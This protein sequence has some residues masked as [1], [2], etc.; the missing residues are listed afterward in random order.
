MAAGK[1][2]YWLLEGERNDAIFRLCCSLRRY[3]RDDPEFVLANAAMANIR[4]VPPMSDQELHQCVESAFKQDHDT[5][6]REAS[7]WV[8]MLNASEG[9][10]H[11]IPLHSATNL[12]PFPVHALP[13]VIKNWCEAVSHE[14]QMPIELAAGLVFAVIATAFVGRVKINVKPGWDEQGT[15]Y[16]IGLSRPGTMK[17][18]LARRAFAPIVMAQKLMATTAEEEIRHTRARAE[19]LKAIVASLKKDLAKR[20][21][22]P[23]LRNQLEEAQFNLD[24]H[25]IDASRADIQR[26]DS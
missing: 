9:W 14:L 13:P 20:P 16:V 25:T 10:E 19:V 23:D 26:R 7:V 18:A 22:D 6:S 3:Y 5:L 11:P 1:E 8:E 2:T 24:T 21:G 4:C 12:P 15:L 17:S